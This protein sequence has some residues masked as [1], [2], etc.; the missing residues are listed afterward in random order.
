MGLAGGE[1]DYYVASEAVNKPVQLV[2]FND[3]TKIG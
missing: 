2:M 3:G 1:A